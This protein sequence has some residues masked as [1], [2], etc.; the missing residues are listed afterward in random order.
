[1]RK[2]VGGRDRIA[3]A[4][5]ALALFAASLAGMRRRRYLLAGTCWTASGMALFNVVSGYCGVNA[6]LGVDT[7]ACEVED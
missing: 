1:M 4:I 7:C 3:R 5:V 6:L 2:N